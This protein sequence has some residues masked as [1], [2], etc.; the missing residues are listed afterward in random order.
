MADGGGAVS[1]VF[2]DGHVHIHPGFDRVR[3]L[4]SAAKNF[5]NGAESVGGASPSAGL[6]FLTE[7]A[8]ARAFDELSALA[9]AGEGA[10]PWRPVATEDPEALRVQN[11][12]SPFPLF[13]L[14]GRQIVTEENLEVL[15]LATAVRFPENRPL[16]ETIAAVREAGGIPA[17]PWGF[18][19]WTGRRGDRIRALI[20]SGP[21]GVFLGD[22]GGRPSG[23]ARP[24]LL[25]AGARSGFRILPGSDP[26]P[27]PD[28]VR[29]P[30]RYGWWM[31]GPLDSDRPATAAKSLLRNP[32]I[33]F[34]PFGELENPWTF[35]TQQVRMQIR[36]RRGGAP[37]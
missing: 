2:A 5:R 20:R 1:R 34:H 33:P 10:G 37:R 21:D 11:A 4:E 18:G 7:S 28:Q 13:L 32:S 29:K 17:V 8:D 9:A 23:F 15:A 36:K 30:G 24:K 31:P 16:D 3:F 25:D 27:F 35:L 12:E 14:A 26:L 6:L 22:N 19:K